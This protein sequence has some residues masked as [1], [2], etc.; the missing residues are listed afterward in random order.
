MEKKRD[1]GREIGSN[2]PWQWPWQG[3]KQAK[4]VK[5]GDE[6]PA[7]NDIWPTL[8]SDK[9]DRCE[10]Y[11]KVRVLI[12]HSALVIDL[13][14][15]H[16]RRNHKHFEKLGYIWIDGRTEKEKFSKTLHDISGKL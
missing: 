14:G 3:D 1:G 5:T 2:M 7:L 8:G 11:A 12:P 9:C 4:V 15:H 16:F 10:G 6:V 13:C